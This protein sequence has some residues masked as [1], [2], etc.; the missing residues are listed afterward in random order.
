MCR[1][2]ALTKLV[3]ADL[4]LCRVA[5]S[6]GRVNEPKLHTPPLVSAKN[7]LEVDHRERPTVDDQNRTI[8]RAIPVNVTA[9]NVVAWSRLRFGG[10]EAS[11]GESYPDLCANLPECEVR[12]GRRKAF[13]SIPEF[14]IGDLVRSYAPA[15]RSLAATE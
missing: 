3:S 4:Y 2:V 7:A 1:V 14:V 15:R 6:F 10:R 11:G 9:K 8:R 12:V 5:S 13:K